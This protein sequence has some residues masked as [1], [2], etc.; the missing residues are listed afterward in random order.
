LPGVQAATGQLNGLY[1]GSGQYNYAHTRIFNDLT[2]GWICDAQMTPLKFLQA[3]MD[4]IFVDYDTSQTDG[5]KT[6]F[7]PSSFSNEEQVREYNRS[8][9]LNFPSEYQ[10]K[11][12][13]LKAERGDDGGLGGGGEL[14][15]PSIRY[16]FDNIWPYAIDTT[17]LSFGSSQLVKVTA[18]FYYDRYYTYHV[19][20][21]S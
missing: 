5:Y 4:T 3:W 9:R 8:T 7:Q 20:P 17:P 6:A 11:L 1:T 15:R 2:L 16:R 10:A 12:S 13:I 18:N 14:A 21:A 19:K